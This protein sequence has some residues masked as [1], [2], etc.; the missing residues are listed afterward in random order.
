MTR[1]VTPLSD[2]KCEAAKPRDKDYTLLDGQGLFLLVKKNSSKIWRMKF[3][4][5]DGREGLATFGNYPALTLRAARARRAEALE[6]LA[7]GKDPI[8]SARQGRVEAANAR[9]NTFGVLA[10]KWHDACSKKWSPGHA[11]TVWRR[12]E[13]YLLPALG[14]RPVAGLKTRDLLAPLKAVE[15]REVLDTA[16]RLRQ[17]MTGIMRMAVQHGHID[18]NRVQLLHARPSTGLRW[19]WIGCLS[20]CNESTATLVGR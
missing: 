2:S 15:Q 10:K 20:C 11:A 16:A 14:Q 1:T 3:K 7:H 8:E 13:T 17:Y 12:I 9:A 5:P 4:R 18:T 6:L 19:R